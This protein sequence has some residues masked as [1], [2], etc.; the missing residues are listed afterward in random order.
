MVY[1]ALEDILLMHGVLINKFGGSLGIR[2]QGALEAALL[3]PQS[4]YYPDLI[5]EAA[6]LFES[7]AVNHPFVDGNKR[8]A[9]A[10]MDTFLR[11]NGKKLQTNSKETH[12]QIIKMFD[13]QTLKFEHVDTW[14]RSICK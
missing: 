14:L 7:L 8:I 12:K 11:I 10:A 5:A 13:T 4:G 6:A 1:L 2:D 9:F 3:R